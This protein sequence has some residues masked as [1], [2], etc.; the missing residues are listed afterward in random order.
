[1]T[2]EITAFPSPL[3]LADLAYKTIEENLKAKYLLEHRPELSTSH[4]VIVI[5]NS[6][7]MLSKKKD[8]LLYRDSQ[9]A[10]F[11]FT[12]LEFLRGYLAIL[13][14]TP[15]WYHSSNSV[16]IPVRSFQGNLLAGLCITKY[17]RIEIRRNTVIGNVHS[18]LG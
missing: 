9:N 17:W 5:D 3:P 7:S 6:R 4:T 18:A 1:M 12:A 11:S 14:S 10:A 15:T 13:L 16:N 8:V 2:R